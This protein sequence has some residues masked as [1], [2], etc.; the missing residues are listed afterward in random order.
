K[1]TRIASA[2]SADCI[3]ADD[4]TSARPLQHK[5]RWYGLAGGAPGSGPLRFQRHDLRRRAARRPDLLR[6]PRRART[7]A[8]RRRIH[9][10]LLGEPLDAIAIE[11]TEVGIAAA[12]AAGLRTIG[13]TTTLPAER[14]AGADEIVPAVD[15]ALMQRLLG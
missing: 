7:A 13:V 15:L 2:R 11:D 6:H 9:A 3:V 14:L 8:P 5:P 10:A 12:K 1:A 4:A